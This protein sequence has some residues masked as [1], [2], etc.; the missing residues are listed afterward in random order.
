MPS[1]FVLA[2]CRNLSLILACLCL[3]ASTGL[4]ADAPPSVRTAIAAAPYEISAVEGRQ[5]LTLEGFGH[6]QVPGTPR[7]PSRIIAI[8]IPPGAEFVGLSCDPG[9]GVVLPGTYDIAP[10]RLPRVIGEENPDAYARDLA[11]YEASRA[12]VYGSNDAY[13]AAPAEFVRTAGYRRYNLVDVRVTPFAYRPLSGELT[14]YPNLR[15]N[16]NYRMG[17]ST[18]G[19]PAGSLTRCEATAADIVHNYAEAQSWYPGGVVASRGLHDYVIITLDSLTSAVAPLVNWETAKGRTVEV[20]TT[21]WID[22][23]YA[24]YDLA[25]KMRNFLRDKY[26]ADQWGI[27]DVLLVG[28]YDD[29]QIRRTAQDLGYGSPETDFYFAELSLPD[30]ESWDRDEDRKWGETSDPT[31]FYAEVNVGR[32]PWSDAATVQSICEKSVAYE[33]NNDPA[34]KRNILLLGAYFWTTPDPVTDNANLMEAI[35]GQAWMV[36]WTDTRMYEKNVDCYSPIPCD[37]EL[38]HTNV[39]DHWSNAPYA[40]VTWAGHGSPTS[41]HIYGLGMPALIQS[42]DCPSLN[43]DYPAIIFADACSN[44]DTDY[45]NIGRAML[46]QGGVGFLGATKVA[47][48]MPAWDSPYDGSTQSLDY[49]F[50]TRI[51]SGEM[52]QGQAHQWAMREMYTHML[53]SALKYE[54][55]EWGAFLG[56]PNLALREARALRIAFPEGVPDALTPGAVTQIAVQIIDDQQAFVPGTATLHYRHDGGVFNSVPLTPLGGGF[57]EAVL[58]AA[59]CGDTPEFYFSAE[60]DS[61]T[62]ETS[63]LA[64]PSVVFTPSAG[65]RTVCF[66]DNAEFGQGWSAGTIGATSG[67]WERGVPVNDPNWAYDPLADSDGSGKCFLTQNEMGNSDVDNGA[68]FMMSPVIDMSVGSITI[69]YDYYLHLSDEDGTD[70]LVVE[71]SSNG[72]GDPWIELAR[73]DANRG[74]A[75]TNHVITQDDLDAA[76]VTLTDNM[77]VRFTAND[78]DP[79]GA[80]EAGVDA[81]SVVSIECESMPDGDGD[82]VFDIYDNCVGT[83]NPLQEDSDSD[84]VGDACDGCPYDPYKLAPGFCGCGYTEADIDGDGWPNCVDDCPFDPNKVE[85]GICGC[86]TPDD[87]TDADGVEDCIDACPDTPGGTPVTTDGCPDCNGNGIWDVDDIDSGFS[88]DCNLNNVPD[89]CDFADGTLT[90]DNGNGIADQCEGQPGDLNCDGFVNNGDIDAFV[91]AL[92]LPDDYAI[93]FPDCDMAL[94][95]C[96]EDGYANNGDIDAFL[97]LITGS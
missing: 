63:P 42:S 53:W 22:S 64:A 44:H 50:T 62:I 39:M 60:G 5:E 76:L 27:E 52:T 33:Q 94:A 43:D 9:A 65:Q 90:D 92:T 36:D 55:F 96:N 31:D 97:E 40:F 45:A 56:N 21:S 72:G 57:H 51:T 85:P 10:A 23:T 75:W 32:I 80:V 77:R 14:Y 91:L 95:D 54:T 82:G 25:E 6:L 87:D 37:Y 83:Y 15:V 24:G 49:F 58:P 7:L 12:Q 8:A 47:L 69:S 88:V 79:Q 18:R 48:G 34:Y 13:P 26:P 71:I 16:V 3:A 17:Q 67:Q 35:A 61:G 30:D 4:A 1:G 73:H 86:G 66:N 81:I 78:G 89:D 74:L 19:L 2:P 29:V 28:H 20:V 41:S 59:H 68:V 11:R 93:A 70:A 46:K 84:L 38:L